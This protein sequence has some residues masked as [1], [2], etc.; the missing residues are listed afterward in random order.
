M[1]FRAAGVRDCCMV[2]CGMVL[3]VSLGDT[4]VSPFASVVSFFCPAGLDFRGSKVNSG[5]STLPN[6]LS[7]SSTVLL[8]PWL[9]IFHLLG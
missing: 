2:P 1:I 4:S 6:V 8:H 3:L 9:P 5:S 7:C